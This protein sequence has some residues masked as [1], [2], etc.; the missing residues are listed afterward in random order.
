MSRS[1]LLPMGG[2]DKGISCARAQGFG[3]LSSSSPPTVKQTLDAVRKLLNAKTPPYPIIERKLDL[4]LANHPENAEALALLIKTYSMTNRLPNAELLFESALTLVQ[5]DRRLLYAAMISA[6]RHFESSVCTRAFFDRAV[7]ENMDTHSIYRSMIYSYLT[8]HEVNLA[9]EIFDRAFEKD[10]ARE[11][12]AN[13]IIDSMLFERM[14]VAY[15]RLG[16]K[17][18]AR[19]I[20]QQAIER[21]VETSK[22]FERIHERFEFAFE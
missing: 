12:A 7:R 18:E 2:A 14:I 9:R 1:K 15:L 5:K 3:S 10:R 11:T 4:L 16:N 8:N 17:K 6:Y 21:G 22:M 19:R 13:P 20:S